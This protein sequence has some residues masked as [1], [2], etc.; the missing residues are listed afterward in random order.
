M[1]GRKPVMRL[2]YE[3]RVLIGR[4]LDVAM[5]GPSTPDDV[6]CFVAELED[7]GLVIGLPARSKQGQA[8]TGKAVTIH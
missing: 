3:W 4:A 7:L 8:R 6:D 2:P 5:G 1:T